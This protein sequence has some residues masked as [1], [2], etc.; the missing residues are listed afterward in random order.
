M[1]HSLLVA[2]PDLGHTSNCLQSL[3]EAVGADTDSG[4]PDGN[5]DTRMLLIQMKSEA[6][7]DR[8]LPTDNPF[9]L[10]FQKPFALLEVR[11]SDSLPVMLRTCA[12]ADVAD[13][14]SEADLVD[15]AKM[16]DL[17][18]GLIR[19]RIERACMRPHASLEG[20]EVLCRVKISQDRRGVVTE[21][22][23][24]RCNGSVKWQQSL[25][26]AIFS[27]PPL[28][29]PPDPFLFADAVSMLFEATDYQQAGKVEG[30]EPLRLAI[31]MGARSK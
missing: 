31:E 9:P 30:Y 18:E 11:G 19:A 10:D 5:S 13:T 4:S 22:E 8:E 12:D 14:A 17:Y 6:V 23:L 27:A 29:A 16:M 24:Q 15:R 25:V 26:R 3:S 7:V 21:L 20:I 28:P 2:V 1:L